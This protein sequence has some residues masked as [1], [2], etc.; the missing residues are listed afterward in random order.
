MARRQA[1]AAAAG[2]A[3]RRRQRRGPRSRQLPVH[4]PAAL[5]RAQ[6]RR[7]RP[8]PP[9]NA[10][11]TRPPRAA[12]AQQS[13]PPRYVRK[14]VRRQSARGLQTRRNAPQPPQEPAPRRPWLL[15]RRGGTYDAFS[16]TAK[17][18]FQRRGRRGSAQPPAVRQL[19]AALAWPP[20]PRNALPRHP[21]AASAECQWQQHAAGQWRERPLPSLLPPK[22]RRRRPLP[23]ARHRRLHLQA[24]HAPEGAARA[25]QARLRAWLRSAARSTAVVHARRCACFRQ[26][27]PAA[28]ADC[29]CGTSL[30]AQRRGGRRQDAASAGVCTTVKRVRACNA[31]R[32]QRGLGLTLRRIRARQHCF[33]HVLPAYPAVGANTPRENR[34]AA[35]CVP[36]QGNGS[37]HSLCRLKQPRMEAQPDCRSRA[38]LSWRVA[39]RGAEGGAAPSTH[40]AA[41]GAAQ[42]RGATRLYRR[43]EVRTSAWPGRMNTAQPCTWHRT[44]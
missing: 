17:K 38:P 10:P 42:G 5:Q 9:C 16:A 26:S 41:G 24:R 32:A 33:A 29:T 35:R 25:F 27:L 40:A 7:R 18:A 31:A 43:L 13:P 28:A 8:P 20:A 36:L 11:A 37:A 3:Q 19:Y 39:R 30:R 15:W 4:P 23:R 6:R 22:R 12:A 1:A 2:A 21:G 34:D 14:R 44:T